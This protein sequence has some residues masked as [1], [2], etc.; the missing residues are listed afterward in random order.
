MW[1]TVIKLVGAYFLSK[2]VK[3]IVNQQVLPG[4]KSYVSATSSGLSN[5]LARDWRR[6]MTTVIAS[7]VAATTFVVG[8]IAGLIWFV[9]WAIDQPH[10]DWLF[11]GIFAVPLI[12]G[13]CLIWYIKNL[14]KNR[15]LLSDT[16]VQLRQQWQVFKQN[17][18]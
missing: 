18:Q 12:F 10:R 13:L 7:V 9:V 17:F 16:Q 14:W 8:A 2:Q 3:T 11:A 6:I 1:R 15:P 5:N 4:V